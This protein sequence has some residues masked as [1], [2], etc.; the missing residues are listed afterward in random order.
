MSS[1]NDNAKLR[2]ALRRMEAA[3][4]KKGRVAV[5]ALLLEA[6]KAAATV[7][8]LRRASPLMKLRRVGPDTALEI[9]AA[10]GRKMGEGE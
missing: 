2:I 5:D 6:V 9:R 10:V 3:G 7:D 1:M 8:D 4:G